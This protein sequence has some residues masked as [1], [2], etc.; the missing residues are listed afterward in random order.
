MQT[1]KFDLDLVDDCPLKIRRLASQL[2]ALLV[3][4]DVPLPVDGMSVADV[5]GSSG[6]AYTGVVTRKANKLRRLSGSGL[7]WYLQSGKGYAGVNYTTLPALPATFEDFLTAWLST[8]GSKSNQI[9]KGTGYSASTTAINAWTE[10]PA[11]ETPPVKPWID[12]LAAQ[13]GNE[14]RITTQG[15]I[16][17]GVST[18]LFRSTPNVVIC[19]GLDGREGSSYRALKVAQFDMSTDV[20]NY[21]NAAY[22]ETSDTIY[23]AS[24]PATSTDVI[25]M[26]RMGG[27][28]GNVSLSRPYQM[29]QTT[30]STDV[31][32][33]ITAAANLYCAPN[34]E[35]NCTVDEY[36]IT[37][38]IQPG[39]WLYV[40]SPDD[41]FY[42]SANSIAIGGQVLNPKSIR[43]TGYEYPV[44]AGMGVYAL[45]NDVVTDLT[46]FVKWETGRPTR[47]EFDLRPKSLQANADASAIG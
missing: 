43:C 28:G 45:Y 18:S 30:S 19:P 8:S 29:L 34:Y 21:R 22:Y 15:Y 5:L 14:Y 47:L 25:Y 35:I 33:T 41:D 6:L 46:N 40:Y 3:V 11:T 4:A 2:G 9:G 12:V 37:T 36:N 27:S 17:F 13:T 32:N 24:G 44:Q 31:D 23:K 16:D 20:E 10:A 26:K 1:G 39:D 7:M 42:D 38:L